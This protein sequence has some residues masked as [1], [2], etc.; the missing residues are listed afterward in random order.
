MA[1]VARD[2][3]VGEGTLGNRVRQ[4]R[5]GRSGGLTA[6]ERAELARLRKENATLRNRDSLCMRLKQPQGI[7]ATARTRRPRSAATSAGPRCTADRRS[8]LP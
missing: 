7:T 2:L 8:S 6:D 4:D 3:G 1:Q 5:E